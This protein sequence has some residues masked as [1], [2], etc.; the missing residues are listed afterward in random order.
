MSVTRRRFLV[1]STACLGLLPFAR[2]AWAQGQPPATRFETIRRNVG[3]FV[4]RGGTIGWL[5]NGDAVVVV[6]TQFADTAKICLEGLAQKSPRGI[7]LLFN[8]HHHGDHTSGNGVFK[9]NTK[10]IVAHARV[11]ALQKEVAAAALKKNPDAGAPVV[12]DATFDN[13]WSEEAGDERISAKHYGPGHTGGDAVIRFERAE[14]V[15]MGDLLFHER[16][17][18]VDRPAGASIQNRM[19]T[20]E[21]VAKEMPGGTIYIAG[22]SREGL[23]VT[24]DRKA[25]ERFRDYF[26]AVLSHVRKGIAAGSSKEEVTKLEALPGFEAYQSAPPLLTLTAVL[27]DAYDE[28]TAKS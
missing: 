15:H 1:H 9:P 3:Y 25:L 12:A 16:H 20:L 2:H 11:P 21:A 28:L 8:T 23:P 24:V 19:K 27:G 6:D 17:P 14:V 5:V 18:R 13:V 4:G 10:K 26:D 22:H 7:D